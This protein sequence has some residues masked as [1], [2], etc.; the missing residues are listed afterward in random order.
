[1]I[2]L[3]IIAD[4]FT[5]ALDAGAPFANRCIPTRVVVSDSM[6]QPDTLAGIR[7]LSID[8]ETR[9]LSPERAYAV[10]LSL[11]QEALRLGVPSICKKVDSTL[12]GQ[13][14]SE[15]A[16]LSDGANGGEVAFLPAFPDAGRTT[17]G[18]MQMLNGVPIHKTAFG[19][20]PFEPVKTA[21]VADT[22]HEQ[23]P[24]K[25][26][27]R[28]C[29][30]PVQGAAKESCIAV[31]DSETQ[32]AL[33][34]TVNKLLQAGTRLWAGCAGLTRELALHMEH[35]ETATPQFPLKNGSFILCGSM[36]P[37]A[38][39][40]LAFAE[41]YGFSRIVLTK[42]QKFAK[43]F[44]NDPSHAALMDALRQASRQSGR[45]ILDA[46]SGVADETESLG[47][48]REEAR[49]QVAGR[50]GELAKEWMRFGFDHLIFVTGGDTLFAW[51]QQ[52]GFP[53]LTPVGELEAG[54]V[55]SRFSWNGQDW[56][57]VTKAGGFGTLD[58]YVRITKKLQNTIPN[59]KGGAL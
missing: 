21:S 46:S 4:D 52:L 17:V 57:L 56:L 2:D 23:S 14:G 25:V 30:E 58:T 48:S 28:S 38:H 8:A 39:D 7:V 12:R 41:K 53:S 6:P 5:G 27:N 26:K 49:I 55:C 34:D 44:S 16:A 33:Q 13:V 1:M 19:S 35:S 54:V 15:L 36:N 47:G 43:D 45:V 20:D 24:I 31:Y 32:A 29:A 3:L 22:I 42:E 37:I 51:M 9:H 59:Q 18:G 11:V 10:T 50:I 40:Q